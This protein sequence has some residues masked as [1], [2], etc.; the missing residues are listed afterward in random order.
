[1]AK[2]AAGATLCDYPQTFSAELVR[3]CEKGCIPPEVFVDARSLLNAEKRRRYVRINPRSEK[4]VLNAGAEAGLRLETHSGSALIGPSNLLSPEEWKAAN[5]LQSTM[6]TGAQTTPMASAGEAIAPPTG[7]YGGCDTSLRANMLRIGLAALTGLPLESV[8]PVGW[9]PYGVFSLPW[10]YSM[11]RNPLFLDGT[12][13][14][15]DAA[16]IAAVVALHPRRGDRVL[17]LCCAPGMKMGLLADAVTGSDTCS[18]P[19]TA[20]PSLTSGLVVGVDLSLS[21]LYRTRSTLKKQQQQQEPQEQQQDS[22]D[23]QPPLPVCLFAGDGCHFS[24]RSA[25]LALDLSGA[26]VNTGT[27]L[28]TVERRRLRPQ[29]DMAAKAAGRKRSRLVL[30]ATTSSGSHERRSSPPPS[31]V[32]ASAQ[33]RAVVAAWLQEKTRSSAVTD[34]ATTPPPPLEPLLFDRVLVDAEC[35]HDGSVAHMQLIEQPVNATAAKSVFSPGARATSSA[36]S[37]AWKSGFFDNTYRMHRMNLSG[38]TSVVE[39]PTDEGATLLSSKPATRRPRA[40]SDDSD[41]G[42]DSPLS[43]ASLFAL[44][45]QLLDNG[46]RQLRPGGTLVYST[47][48]YSYLQNEYVVR[49]FLER[50][51]GV[52]DEAGEGDSPNSCAGNDIPGKV[53]AVLVP[54]FSY[55]HEADETKISRI[56]DEDDDDSVAPCVRIDSEE[57]RRDLQRLLDSH[58]FDYG[59][60]QNGHDSWSP[61]PEGSLRTTA[62]T[63]SASEHAVVGSRFWPRIFQSSFIYVAKIWKKPEVTVSTGRGSVDVASGE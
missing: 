15:M 57:K 58:A 38:A 31:V 55:E 13:L 39:S 35:S 59:T 42:D 17:D 6:R 27:G 18:H 51:N 41:K 5:M 54:A 34:P 24:M 56:F 52:A 20:S 22:T 25:A 37:A 49:Q 46:Y 28:T 21:R 14:A 7:N 11:G 53:T 63:A 8:E 43:S 62:S 29:S 16:S 36:A 1:M 26:P 45:S 2:N 30:E 3:H 44:Q 9:L 32:Y 47:C 33:T 61:C 40:G 19:S 50:V 23:S 60:V 12:L 10:S 4:R 48:S